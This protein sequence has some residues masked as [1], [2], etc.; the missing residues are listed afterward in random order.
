MRNVFA[1]S[2]V[3]LR[4][5]FDSGS[6]TTK[7][8]RKRLS[9]VGYAVLI[10]LLGICVC[11]PLGFGAYSFAHIIH[12]NGGDSTGFWMLLIPILNVILAVIS[13]FSVISV[14][15]LSMDNEALLPLPLKPWEIIVAR[16][17]TTVVLLYLFTLGLFM[18]F[19]VG[20]GI[21]FAAPVG[22]YFNGLLIIICAPLIPV[23][24]WGIILSLI[25]RVFVFSKHR[26]FFT[27]VFVGVSLLLSFSFSISFN[28][29]APQMESFNENPEA[30]NSFNELVD[31]FIVPFARYFPI[32]KPQMLALS[33]TNFGIGFLWA[34]LNV[35]IS[36]AFVALFA[37]IGNKIYL[38]TMLGS[39]ESSAK[40]KRMDSKEFDKSLKNRA[41][42]PSLIRS[43]WQLIVRSPNYFLNL[44][45][46]VF[47]VPIV[48]V[49]SF[50]IALASAGEEG[51]TENLITLARE[52]L[53]FADPLVFSIFLGALLF[54]ASMNMISSTAVSRMGKDAYFYKIIPVKANTIIFSKVCLG[55]LLSSFL[56]FLIL[57]II[58]AMG[59]LEW[60][61]ALL[62]LV[63]ANV[64]YLGTNYFGFYLDL[65][66]PR[67]D[68]ANETQAVKNN[69][70]S[71]IY[72]LTS[73]LGV[74]VMIGLSLL[75]NLIPITWGTYLYAGILFII[76][77]LITLYFYNKGKAPTF[78]VFKKIQ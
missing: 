62:L 48:M 43:E 67:L 63:V 42:L 60:Y 47:I 56:C 9:K 27:Y 75:I 10:L 50:V 64:I 33:S 1:L 73:I 54:F 8:S 59:I 4:S 37:L 38:K 14:F 39:G 34:L 18:P 55:W 49:L 71:L 31:S 69:I 51:E 61:E 41:I 77:G 65:R 15:F 13:I 57:V 28:L 19:I 23:S 52:N 74:G 70:S 25:N 17:L 45:A 21:G 30:F 12:I 26:D 53:N 7:K 3:L 2:K 76:F 22:Y 29:I 58:F 16:F 5:L 24:I 20:A 32:F 6:T 78:E 44:V 46:M 11:L 72:T 40:K 35:V 68:W 66:K 36:V